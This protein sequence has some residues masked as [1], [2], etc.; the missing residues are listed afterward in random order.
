[1]MRCLLRLLLVTILTAAADR[2]S[3]PVVFWHSEGQRRGTTVLALG[4]GLAGATIELCSAS[5]ADG[6]LGDCSNTTKVLSSW[7]GA[8]TFQ[9]PGPAGSSVP[10][11]FRA[12]IGKS[13]SIFLTLNVPVVWW[14][15]G[16]ASFGAGATATQGSGWLKVYGRSLGFDTNG[17]CS[18]STIESI[19]PAVGTSAVLVRSNGGGT[20]CILETQAAS[21]YDATFTLPACATPG[22]WTLQV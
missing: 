13:C 4:G 18:P 22:N 2:D 15:Q 21:C 17:Q 11:K 10:Y 9:L 5:L 14:A 19:G 1:M 3:S 16:D 8:V 7:A 12:C 20:R 6:G